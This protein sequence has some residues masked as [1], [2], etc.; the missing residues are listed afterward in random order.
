MDEPIILASAS[1]RRHELLSMIGLHYEVHSPMVDESETGRPDERV[2]CLA[3]KKAQA[4]AVDYPGRIIL[5]ADTLVFAK[6]EILGKPVD[7]AD[8]VRMLGLLQND[9]HEVYTG[10]CVIDK[11]GHEHTGV[12]KTLV[13]FIPIRTEEI[14]A[15]VDSG[16]P[17]GKAGAYA[18]QGIAGMFISGIQG[19]YS[20]VIGLPL[21]MVRD[22]L[23]Q[24]GRKLF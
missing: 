7:E 17:F 22:L 13:E 3:R 4:V 24:A 12:E 8:A 11:T 19:S 1:P 5:A 23:S 14:Q 6:G 21:H 10:V 15:Y 9:K 2:L 16:E 20:N 18:I